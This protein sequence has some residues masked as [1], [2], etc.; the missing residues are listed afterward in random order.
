MFPGLHQILPNFDICF[1]SSIVKHL[2]FVDSAQ[3]RSVPLAVAAAAAAA[4]VYWYYF[5]INFLPSQSL[6]S[7][8]Y[9]AI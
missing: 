9:T 1:E 7:L 8:A 6:A 4:T 3:R 2:H 5:P